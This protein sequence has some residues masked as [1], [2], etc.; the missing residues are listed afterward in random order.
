M[1]LLTSILKTLTMIT[2]Q[3]MKMINFRNVYPY[4]GVNFTHFKINSRRKIAKMSSAVQ[5]K[6]IIL[7]KN[8]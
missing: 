8:E 5:A 6:T 3:I 7:L 2:T 1:S 4:S